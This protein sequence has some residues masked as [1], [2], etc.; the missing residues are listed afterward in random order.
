M[1]P[2]INEG[3]LDIVCNSKVPLPL[4]RKNNCACVDFRVEY[5]SIERIQ[6]VIFE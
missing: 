1:I 3:D 2:G 4:T 5:P 6:V